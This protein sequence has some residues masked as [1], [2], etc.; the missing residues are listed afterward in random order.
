MPETRPANSIANTLEE[1]VFTGQVREGERLDERLLAKKFGELRTLVRKALQLLVSS[2]LAKQRPRRGVFV[3][4]PASTTVIEMFETMAEIEA[5]CG[6]LAAQR[7]TPM[8]LE[9]LAAANALCLQAL[10]QQ[11]A[12]AYS[13]H[14]EAFQRMIYRCSGNDFLAAQALRLYDR[15]RPYRRVQ[16]R[17]QARM[18]QSMAEHQLLMASLADGRATDAADILR[19]HVGRQGAR[20]YEEMA[21]L[22]RTAANRNVG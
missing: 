19:D 10:D 11:N 20:F 22:R 14:N 9:N 5:V 21:R 2:K 12:D 6:R 16:F 7:R 13:H 18:T 15:L 1:M 8:A 17:M 3:K 4:Q